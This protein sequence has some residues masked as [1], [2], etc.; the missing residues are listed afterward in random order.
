MATTRV[1]ANRRYLVL[2]LSTPVLVAV[3]PEL[4]KASTTAFTTVFM[5][6]TRDNKEKVNPTKRPP[7]YKEVSEL[8]KKLNPGAMQEDSIVES[9]RDGYFLTEDITYFDMSNWKPIPD[10]MK[11]P[12]K[13]SPVYFENFL[14]VVKTDTIKKIKIYMATSGSGIERLRCSSYNDSLR[15]A[16][17]PK[18]K[19][20]KIAYELSID[21]SQEPVGQ[22]FVLKICGTFWDSFRGKDDNWAETYTDSDVKHLKKLRLVVTLPPNKKFAAPEYAVTTGNDYKDFVMYRGDGRKLEDRSKNELSWDIEK[23]SSNKLYKMSWKWQ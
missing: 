7:A 17:E 6:I 14:R 3:G 20:H 9:S 5:Y 18:Q 8:Q 4:V 13:Y 19:S 16:I 22:P 23:P 11:N 12:K 1:S 21:V 2:L 15:Y 10:T